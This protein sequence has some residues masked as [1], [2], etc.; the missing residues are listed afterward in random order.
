MKAIRSVLLLVFPIYLFSCT[1]KILPN[2]LD[3]ATDSTLTKEVVIPEMRI[4][5]NDV[6]SI[7]VYSSS[8]DPA[9]DAPYNLPTTVASVGTGSGPGSAQGGFLVDTKGNIEYPRLGNFHAEGL[10]REELA[11]QIKKRLIEP[12]ELLKNPVVIVRFQ[13]LKVTILGEVNGQGIISI[14]AENVTIIEAIGL[15]GGVTEYGL[16]NS[17]RVV[18]EIDGKREMGV[19]D[20]SAG[21][22]FESPYY[23]LKQNDMVFIDPTPRK[24]RQAD[25]NLVMQRISFGLTL[26]TAFTLIYSFFN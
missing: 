9:A 13:N 16:K 19:I 21:N 5:K 4:Q 12:V 15:A 10:T 18:R 17:V 6:L 2:Y 1:P 26:I 8:L 14:P 7:R 23:Y 11:E 3:K 24:A 20:L 22:V 25:Q